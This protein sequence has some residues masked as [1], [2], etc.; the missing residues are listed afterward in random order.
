M[1]KQQ[2]SMKATSLRGFLAFVM[3]L[4]IIGAAAGF[5]VGL[6]YV[7]DFALE[8][9]QTLVDADASADRIDQLRELQVSLEESDALV[10][11]AQAVYATPESYQ[12]QAIRD[13][14]RYADVSGVTIEDIAFPASVEPENATNSRTIEVTLQNPA[15][16]TDVIRFLQLIEGNIPKIQPDTVSIARPQ[17]PTNDTVTVGTMILRMAVQ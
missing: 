2:S 14:Q 4:S 11:K 9:N 17:N 5:Y 12:S 1:S 3:V 7:R 8:T 6:Q 13:L 10:Q 15:T 16:Y